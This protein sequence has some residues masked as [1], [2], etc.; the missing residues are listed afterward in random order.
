MPQEGWGTFPWHEG[1]SDLTG[2]WGLRQEAL[3]LPSMGRLSPLHPVD[4]LGWEVH[5]RSRVG[6]VWD[7]TIKLWVSLVVSACLK[8][9]L[10]QSKGIPEPRDAQS[11]S[12]FH[13]GTASPGDVALVGVEG[14][15]PELLSWLCGCSPDGHRGTLG[16]K[17]WSSPGFCSFLSAHP[18][19][20]D[21]LLVS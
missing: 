3:A 9:H 2:D 1:L 20:V 13:P 5:P 12:H 7:C 19:A 8:G 21:S 16:P 17:P 14:V 18:P 15:G 10:G 6:L 4:A 11:K